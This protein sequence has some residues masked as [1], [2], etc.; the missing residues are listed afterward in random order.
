MVAPNELPDDTTSSALEGHSAAGRPYRR[1]VGLWGIL[2]V[3]VIAFGDLTADRRA[4][5]GRL[6]E[7]IADIVQDF[8]GYDPEF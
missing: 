4:A 7:Q 2:L 8:R 6:A 3:L 5:L 1:G